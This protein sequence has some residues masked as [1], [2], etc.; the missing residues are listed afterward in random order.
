[1]CESIM[2]MVLCYMNGLQYQQFHPL[3][4]FHPISS[5]LADVYIWPHTNKK[6]GGRRR[7]GK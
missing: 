6:E 3:Q 5:L 7:E 1:M 4:S 2:G